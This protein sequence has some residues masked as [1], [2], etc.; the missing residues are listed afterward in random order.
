MAVVWVVESPASG[1]PRITSVL[2]GLVAVRAFASVR[3]MLRVASCE[4]IPP[5]ASPRVVLLDPALIRDPRGFQ[6]LA[7][8]IDDVLG[9]NGWHG[10][11]VLQA[12][13]DSAQMVDQIRAI[14]G[15]VHPAGAELRIRRSGEL[16]LDLDSRKVSCF[17]CGQHD[18]ISPT[19]AALL[20][21]LM[22]R[23]GQVISRMELIEAV[24]HGVKIASRSL[25]AHVSRLRKK[26]TFS[27]VSI[28]TAYGDGYRLVR[29]SGCEAA[30]DRMAASRG[31]STGVGRAAPSLEAIAGPD[32][33]FRKSQ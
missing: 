13:P 4:H 31:D 25:D 3:S 2:C 5:G 17:S 24:W 9:R 30:R 23:D 28:D 8:D 16:T 32:R 6:R 22:E 18:V 12:G 21:H 14:L 29:G 19:E 20:R 33:A 1:I 7:C 26:I 15:S 27:G 11:S 10:I